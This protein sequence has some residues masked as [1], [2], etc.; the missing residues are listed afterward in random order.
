MKIGITGHTGRLGGELWKRGCEPLMCD[1]RLPESVYQ[2]VSNVKPDVIIHCAALTNVDY[3]ETNQK[4]AKTINVDG[5]RNLRMG[6]NGKIIHISTDYI[7]DG[8]RGPY[9]EH[10]TP[11]PISV[12]G[13]TKYNAEKIISR[14]RA[15]GMFPDDVI[16]RTTILYGNTEKNDFVSTVLKGLTFH[17]DLPIKVTKAVS[18]SPTYVPHLAD[19]LINI[20]E[21]DTRFS[22]VI[23]VAGREVL[24][25][26]EFA[27]MIAHVFNCDKSMVQYT[28]KVPG[29]ATRPMKAGLKTAYA[30]GMDIP[31]YS[32]HEGLED[33]YCALEYV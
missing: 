11:N 4:E 33:L 3:C 24:T 14:G 26:Y 29:A 13:Q 28:M 1:I 20:A 2:A 22:P 6:Y 16:I 30:E 23:N 5:T 32:V 7:F 31:I 17:K 21:R 18:G 12:Y 9:S 10:A 19:A 8:K 27:L 25:R 15:D